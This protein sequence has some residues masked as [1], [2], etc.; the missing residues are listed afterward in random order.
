MWWVSVEPSARVICSG[1]ISSL[2]L[3]AW[4]AAIA[5]WWLSIGVSVEFV[6]GEAVF[7]RHHLRAGELAELDVRIALL[8]VRALVVAKAVLGRQRRG[9]AHRHPRHRLDAGGDHDVHGA[10][11]H[12]LRGEMQ[13]LL[14]RAALPVDRGAGHAFRQLRGHDGVARDVVGLLAGLHH[15]AHDDVFDLRGIGAG[16]LDQRVQHGGGEIGRMP[17]GEASS[18]AAAGGACGGDDI[19]LGHLLFSLIVLSGFDWIGPDLSGAGD[20]VNQ[21]IN[22]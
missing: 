18:L 16:A 19:S 1:M 17:A 13:R 20:L 5:R 3:P 14:R 8:D 11:H 6:F 10:G 2:N 12:R 21:S 9:E 4:V 22:S 15:A 7:L